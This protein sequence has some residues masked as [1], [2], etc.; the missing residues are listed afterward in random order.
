M[1]KLR[2]LCGNSNF[3]NNFISAYE[4]KNVFATQF[5]PEKS[6]ENGFDYF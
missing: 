2:G 5:H 1:K 6:H 4:Y 3:N